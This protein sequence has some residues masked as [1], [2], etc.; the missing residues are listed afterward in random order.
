MEIRRT[1]CIIPGLV[2]FIVYVLLFVIPSVLSAQ[3]PIKRYTVKNGIMYIEITKDIR[4]AALD[5]FIIQFNLQEL[6]LKDFLKK[7]A[8]D[9]LKKKGWKVE[10]NSEAGFVISK[11][12]PPFEKVNNPVDRIL[13]TERHPTFAERFPPT[14]NGIIFG[15]NRFRNHFPFHQKDSIVTFYLRNNNRANT[16]MLAGSFNDWQPNALPM[17]KVDSGWI[18]HVKLRPG[19]YWYKFIVNG[20][21]RVDDDNLLKE[22]DGYGNINS[23]LFITN[24]TFFIKGHTDAKNASLAGSFNQWRPGELVMNKTAS[25]WTLPLYLAEGTH[26]YKFIADGRWFTDEINNN[27]LPDGE[28]GFNSFVAL[29]KPYLFKLNGYEN[30]KEV[31]LAGSFNNWRTFELPMNKTKNGWELP[32]VIASGNHEYKFWV[33][34][35]LIADPSNPSLID[36]GNSLLIINPNYTFRLKG[37]GNAKKVVLSGDFNK[38][39]SNSLLMRREGD[40]W[41]FPVHLSVG[42]HVYKFVVDGQWIRDP[43]NKLWEQNEFGT[44]NSIVWIDQ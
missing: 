32:Y 37:Y 36:N 17:T 1:I 7:N 16:V 39:N 35:S 26:T 34:G 2:R 11:V 19:K 6:Y 21:W 5:S 18:T 27:K 25:G 13:F 4:E 10:K 40:E 38:W 28:G 23:V 20:N 12:I 14:N 24:T 31:R 43:G 33:D 30:A 42:K 41:V 8:A 3:E 15:Y 9:S 44:G 22:N 29:G